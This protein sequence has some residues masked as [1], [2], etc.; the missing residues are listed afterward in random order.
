MKFK[1][2]VVSVSKPK[3]RDV[4]AKIAGLGK[5]ED[6]GRYAFCTGECELSADL[7]NSLKDLCLDNMAGIIAI[8]DDVGA[9]FRI[10]KDGNIFKGGCTLDDFS[11][12]EYI[13]GD[14]DRAEA[15]L[16]KLEL[17]QI[18]ALN[19]ISSAEFDKL[20]G[21]DGKMYLIERVPDSM[22]AAC[23]SLSEL[24]LPEGVREVGEYAFERCTAL[25]EFA[26]PST[27][28]V[29][30]KKSFANCPAKKAVQAQI[31]KNKRKAK[32]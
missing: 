10:D 32:K 19:W 20:S 18:E 3:L 21:D 7:K 25:G 27:L 5:I 16:E 29:V 24:V 6:D 14:G 23:T 17:E 11:D 13:F 28:I 8:P 26:I 22:C 2:K 15:A 1:V 30:D 31:A 9:G 4:K 12:N